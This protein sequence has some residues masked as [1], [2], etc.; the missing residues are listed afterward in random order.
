MNLKITPID[1]RKQEFKK[2]LQGY[3]RNEVHGFLE[4]VANELEEHLREHAA[5]LERIRDLDGKIED[6]RN[7]EKTLQDTLLNAQKTVDELRKNAQKEAELILRNA[8]LK[9]EEILSGAKNEIAKL[10]GDLA[11]LRSEKETYLAQFEGLL[12]AQQR[13]LANHHEGRVKNSRER[14][15]PSLIGVFEK[16]E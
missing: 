5:L 13:V 7:M 4:M 6:Y 1:L 3:D 12:Q 15:I 2:A 11:S 9:A 8:R 16:L 14:E 10:R